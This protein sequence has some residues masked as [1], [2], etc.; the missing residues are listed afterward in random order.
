MILCGDTYMWLAVMGLVVLAG[1]FVL[2]TIGYCL[3]ADR[4]C[5]RRGQ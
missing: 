2:C 3:L 4:W 5:D 1:I